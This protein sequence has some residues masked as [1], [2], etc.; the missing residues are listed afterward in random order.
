MA[1]SSAESDRLALAASSLF[2]S[3]CQHGARASANIYNLIESAKVIGRQPYRYLGWLL[4]VLLD[5]KP[6]DIETVVA[7]NMPE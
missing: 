4:S 5:T 6:E 1:Q 7:W 2:R 3:S